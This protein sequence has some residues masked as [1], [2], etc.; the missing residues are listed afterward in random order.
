M[1]PV[2]EEFLSENDFEVVLAAFCCYEYGYVYCYDLLNRHNQHLFL[3]ICSTYNM[4]DGL[5][6]EKCI[7]T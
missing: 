5:N 6:E 7:C 3:T 2:S 1:D 4:N